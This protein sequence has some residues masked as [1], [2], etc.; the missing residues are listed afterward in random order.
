MVQLALAVSA[1]LLAASDLPATCEALARLSLDGATVTGTETIGPGDWKSPDGDLLPGL[2]ATCRVTLRLLASQGDGRRPPRR[3]A[4]EVARLWLAIDPRD[5]GGREAGHPRLLWEATSSRLLRGLLPG[6]E[7][8]A[9]GGAALPGGLRRDRRGMRGPGADP[10]RG[11]GGLDAP[12]AARPRSPC[13]RPRRSRRCAR[14][15]SRPAAPPTPG[16]RAIPGSSTP[17]PARLALAGTRP[18]ST[19]TATR[20]PSRRSSG[21]C[22]TPRP[23]TCPASRGAGESSSSGTAGW[24]S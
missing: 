12:R 4:G 13:R 8:G 1:V 9:H 20:R 24:T 17:Q 7:A 18:A 23:P 3:P 16:R 10:H 19:S 6:R 11:P 2:P 22:W 21:R 14:P 15:S 5:R